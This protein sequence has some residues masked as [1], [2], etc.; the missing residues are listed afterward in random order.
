MPL[1]RVGDDYVR[2][3]YPADGGAYRASDFSAQQVLE[4]FTRERHE[5]PGRRSP[6]NW[7]EVSRRTEG[8][9]VHVVYQ[10]LQYDSAVEVTFITSPSGLESDEEAHPL[11]PEQAYAIALEQDEFYRARGHRIYNER[12]PRPA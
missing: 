4:W 12:H 10:H 8:G 9:R 2:D 1:R 5:N 3:P 6:D 7:T 11:P